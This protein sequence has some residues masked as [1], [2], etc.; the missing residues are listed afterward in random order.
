MKYIKYIVI[1]FIA[2]YVLINVGAII[3]YNIDLNNYINNK[4]STG[5]VNPQESISEGTEVYVMGSVHFETANIKRDDI[6][7][8]LDSLSPSVILYERDAK[9]VRRM[10][11]RTDFFMQLMDVFKN[12]SK[13]ESF[14][15]H[16]YVRNHPESEVLPFEW[17]E[18]DSYHRKHKI[19]TRSDEVL[20]SVNRLFRENKLT[21]DQSSIVEKFREVNNEYYRIGRNGNVYDLNNAST[22]SLNRIRQKYVYQYIPEIAKEKEELE[23]LKDFLPI[24]M[25]YWDIRNKAMTANILNQIRNNQNERI[26]VLTGNTH[27]YYLIDE[28]KKYE[29]EFNFSVN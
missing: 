14:V 24:H 28:L 18:R 9:G 12:R 3:K 27:R 13:V 8:Y 20:S 16:K 15:V 1:T 22:D 5:S 10:M 25:E 26:V 17:A 11:K 19:L 23:N 21:E 7:H 6:Y 29:E 4:G 2:L